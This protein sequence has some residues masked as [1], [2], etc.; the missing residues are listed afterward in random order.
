MIAF[1][2]LGLCVVAETL[3]ELC[4]KR[5]ADAGNGV[6][7]AL[8]HPLTWLGI[9]LWA[10]QAVAWIFT[11]RV[12]PLA[13]AYPVN[14]LTYVTVPLAGWLVLREKLS[15]RQLWASVLIASGVALI[16]GRTA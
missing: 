5:A 11:L 1:A 14:C 10:V 7:G 6:A 4:Y 2:L 8:M 3:L 9:G 16:A 12:L 13:I 15:P